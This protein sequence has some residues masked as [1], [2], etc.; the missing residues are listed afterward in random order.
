MYVGLPITH[1]VQEMPLLLFQAW[2]KVML[3]L[4]LAHNCP[5]RMKELQKREPSISLAGPIKICDFIA[6]FLHVYANNLIS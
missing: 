4:L 3:R 1:G 2:F 5:Q 6:A